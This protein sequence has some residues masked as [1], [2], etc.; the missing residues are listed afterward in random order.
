[1]CRRPDAYSGVCEPWNEGAE[2]SR[3][4]CLLL[5]R[6]RELRC[7]AAID[8]YS[9]SLMNIPRVSVVEDSR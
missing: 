3:D 7:D 2:G 4:S 5:E 1:M 8:Q 6:T 9:K